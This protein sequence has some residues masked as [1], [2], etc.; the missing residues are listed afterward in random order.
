MNCPAHCQLQKTD[1][2]PW[3][4]DMSTPRRGRGG[5]GGKEVVLEVE[6]GRQMFQIEELKRWEGEGGGGKV[7]ICINVVST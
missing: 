5:E 3:I 4:E 2:S 6:G 1:L 7:T